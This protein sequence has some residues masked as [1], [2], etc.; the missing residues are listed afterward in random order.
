MNK[1]TRTLMA[2]ATVAGRNND[3]IVLN[4]KKPPQYQKNCTM[5]YLEGGR[6]IVLWLIG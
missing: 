4:R 2:T 1:R 5:P 3:K 6:R